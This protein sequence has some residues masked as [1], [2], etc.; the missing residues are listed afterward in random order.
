MGIE[1][2]P[3]DVEESAE[4]PICP[5]TKEHNL[6]AND[7][8]S[9]VKADHGA[10]KQPQRQNPSPPPR[11]S[12]TGPP[13]QQELGSPLHHAHTIEPAQL[14]ALLDVNTR[15]AL[16]YCRKQPSKLYTNPCISHG[17]SSTESAARLERDG[18]NRVRDMEG[19]SVWKIL[20]R[21]VSNSLTLV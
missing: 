11:F 16:S 3:P 13:C 18:P 1:T 2:S 7:S 12:P 19:L 15:Y 8:P 4:P 21:Q 20:L 14:A 9:D 5:Y 10:E 17:L 6:Q